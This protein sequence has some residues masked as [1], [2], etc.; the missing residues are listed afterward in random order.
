MAARRI[1]HVVGPIYR[2]IPEDE[3]ELTEAVRAA[4]DASERL[5]AAS[6]ALPAI[7]AGIYGYPPDEAC[8]VI[9]DAVERWLADGGSL[10]EVRLVAF[11]AD[12][13]EGFRQALLSSR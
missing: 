7:S 5:G 2:G 12:V 4:L 3:I 8:R 13:A 9:V 1:V 10:Q 11:G 6:I